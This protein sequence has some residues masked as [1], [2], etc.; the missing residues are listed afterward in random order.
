MHALTWLRPVVVAL[1]VV[2]GIGAAQDEQ[3]FTGIITDEE[4]ATGDHSRMK[5][6]PTDADCTKA[7]VVAH[8][9][10]YVLYDGKS[11]YVLSD[12]KT[13][14]AFAAQ[15]VRVTGTLDAKTMTIRVGSI[16]AAALT[17]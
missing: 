1:S 4:C 11:A 14:E 10:R 13:P 7:C 6:G 9:A 17:P 5:M 3:T 8:G 15:R 2:V 16:T 12:Q